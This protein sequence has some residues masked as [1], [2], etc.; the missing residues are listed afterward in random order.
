M[1]TIHTP[2]L[3]APL[4]QELSSIQ[5]WSVKRWETFQLCIIPFWDLNCIG[6]ESCSQITYCKIK[7]YTPFFDVNIVLLYKYLKIWNNS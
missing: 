2:L 7:S 5:I 6:K 4:K 1:F 3:E